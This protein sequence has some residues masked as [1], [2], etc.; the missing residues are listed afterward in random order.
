MKLTMLGTGNALVTKCFNTCFVLSEGKDHFLVDS[1]G[2][3]QIL[4]VLKDADIELTDIHNIFITHEH[5]DHILG[6]VWLIRM[7]GTR[8][9]EGKYKGVL[10]IYSHSDLVPTIQTLA[11]LTVQKKVTNLIGN[12]IVLNPLK[13][14]DTVKIL[15]HKTTFFDIHSSKAKQYG[16]T[17]NIQ[18][19]I[20][21]TC[22]GDEP[23]NEK[24]FEYVKNSDWLMHEAFCLY[25]EKEIFKPYEKHHSTV[26]DACTLGEELK[27]P[28]LI[29]YHT[30][31]THLSERKQLYAK[32]GKKYYNG[33]LYIP[34]DGEQIEIYGTEE[35]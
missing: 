21:F 16:F 8:I 1:G 10:N 26:K 34:D 18:N 35:K 2:G 11:E 12:K 15:G 17:M 28:N 31:E 23:Y 14:G 27:I 13:S 7:I 22:V 20:K 32:E 25:K 24:E 5:A 33:N 3:N 6:I 30:E 4:R 19:K 29:L 9:N